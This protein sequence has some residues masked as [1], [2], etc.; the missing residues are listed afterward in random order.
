MRTF[1]FSVL[2]ITLAF[3]LE[4]QHA[5]AGFSLEDSAEHWFDQQIGL[6]AHELFIGVFEPLNG[7]PAIEEATW[8]NSIWLI[9]DLSYRG[10]LYQNVYLL[11]D[12]EQDVLLIKNH[13]NSQYLDQPIKINQV[14]VAWF[15]I[16]ADRFV[17]RS[18]PKIDAPEGYYQ[19]LFA[20][21]SIGFYAKR[22][23]VRDLD[24][25]QIR[26]LSDDSFY[27]VVNGQANQVSKP[28]SFYR[29]YPEL[30]GQ[31]KPVFK[32]L[33]IRKFEN[34]STRQLIQMAQ[35]CARIFNQS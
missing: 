4:G 26:L 7:R 22:K 20:D 27:L 32:S 35:R 1:T 24:V 6:Q 17:R 3:H 30:K 16:G 33:N 21:G 29:L 15:I 9:G 10:A 2:F 13:L 34:A 12:L 11:Y 19:E 23:K 28:A 18:F 14:Q 5:L 25:N 8:G 31:L